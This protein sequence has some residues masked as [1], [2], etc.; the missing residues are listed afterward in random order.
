MRTPR[1]AVVAP[2]RRPGRRPRH[3]RV[4][5]DRAGRRGGDGL[6]RDASRRPGS[7]PPPRPADHAVRHPVRAARRPGALAARPEDR[8]EPGRV[9]VGVAGRPGVRV[10]ASPRPQVPQRRSR[11]HRGRQVQLRALQGRRRARDARPGAPGGDRRS[12]RRP[13]SPEG[14]VAGLHDLLRHDGDGGRP[15]AAQEVFRAGGRRGLPQAPDRRRPVQVRERHARGRG[16][17]RG[18]SP[19]TGATRPRQAAGHEGRAR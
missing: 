8:R 12:A 14:G 1:R 4:G 2:G 6:A 15:R 9:V 7:I 13:L 17:A 3:A 19:G 16:R 5:A 11:H 18:Q 10:Q